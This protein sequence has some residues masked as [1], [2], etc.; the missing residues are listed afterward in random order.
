MVKKKRLLLLSMLGLE[1]WG[2]ALGREK[3]LC[4]LSSKDISFGQPAPAP[5]DHRRQQHPPSIALQ[6]CFRGA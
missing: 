6:T 1:E 4:L 5:G 3:W 2:W